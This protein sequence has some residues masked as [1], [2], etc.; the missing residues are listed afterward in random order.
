MRMKAIS[1]P[2]IATNSGRF[3][4]RQSW[5][6]VSTGMVVFL[7]DCHWSMRRVMQSFTGYTDHVNHA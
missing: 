1:S 2:V 4:N 7:P 6:S 5:Q 3:R